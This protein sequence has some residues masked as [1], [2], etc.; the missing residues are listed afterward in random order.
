MEARDYIKVPAQELQNLA[1]RLL[2]RYGVPPADAEIVS[3][4][5]VTADLRGIESHGLGR[6]YPYYISRLEQGAL[7]PR[8]NLRLV[9]NFAATFLLD[10]DNGLGHVACHRAMEK[11][12]ELAKIYGVGLGGVR[13]SNHFGIAGYYAM[14]AL[15]EGM[16]GLCLSN[17]QPLV[18]PTHARKRLLGTNPISVA[19]PAGKSRPFV[20]DMATSVVTRGKIEVCLRKDLGIPPGWGADSQ[21]KEASH[22]AQVLEGGGLFPLGGGAETA[23]YKGYGLSAVVDILSGVLTGSGFL[24]GVLSAAL[25]AEPCRAGHFVAAFQVEALMDLDEFTG[26]MDSFIEELQNAPLAEG[27]DRIYVAGEKEFLLWEEHGKNG[28]PLHRKVWAE[29]LDLCARHGVTPPDIL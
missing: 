1:A 21:G 12:I 20:L 22:P 28:V 17:A 6:L 7:N 18:L 15:Q 11:C 10:A 4:V 5:L 25:Q 9:R 24:S 16:I 14:M 26:R 3:E 29:L 19:V 27:S 13:N 23:G 8:P 2:E